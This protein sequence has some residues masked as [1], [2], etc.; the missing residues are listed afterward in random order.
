M[1]YKSGWVSHLG[2]STWA[3]KISLPRLNTARVLWIWKQSQIWNTFLVSKPR[4]VLKANLSQRYIPST[5]N[6]PN[7]Q[8]K[9]NVMHSWTTWWRDCWIK[10]DLKSCSVRLDLLD[11]RNWLK[12]LIEGIELKELIENVELSLILEVAKSDLTS[13]LIEGPTRRPAGRSRDFAKSS[14]WSKLAV[15]SQ[16][17]L[18]RPTSQH[19]RCTHIYIS[20]KREVLLWYILLLSVQTLRRLYS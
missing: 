17:K 8:R 15:F 9:R 12:E 1:V 14:S 10:A 4:P 20:E 6:Q 13:C 2:G 18:S 5:G 11:R 19:R 7:S 16:I 3:N